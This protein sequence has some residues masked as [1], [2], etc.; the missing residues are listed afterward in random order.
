MVFAWVSQWYCV[1]KSILHLRNPGMILTASAMVSRGA[2]CIL[3]THSRCPFS[4]HKVFSRTAF[5]RLRELD[6]PTWLRL[7]FAVGFPLSYKRVIT[8]P[9]NQVLLNNNFP[10]WFCLQIERRINTHGC[11]LD[12]DIYIGIPRQSK[13]QKT[14]SSAGGRPG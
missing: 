12:I 3:S 6:P 7:F 1:A 11:P 8:P 9:R 13:K 2:K 14:I 10:V 4:Y 5:Q